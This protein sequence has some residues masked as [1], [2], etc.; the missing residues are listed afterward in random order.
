MKV[1]PP[2]LCVRRFFDSYEPIL[3][4]ELVPEAGIK[5][6][7]VRTVYWFAR[8]NEVELHA[9]RECPGVERLADELGSVV[10]ATFRLGRSLQFIRQLSAARARG[11]RMRRWSACATV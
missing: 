9:V 4:Q 2:Y 8:A 6:L 11:T 10:V 1:Q 3:V 7:A 5:A